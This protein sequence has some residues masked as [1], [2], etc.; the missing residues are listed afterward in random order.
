[1]K[2]T[3]LSGK[4]IAILTIGTVVGG[5]AVYSHTLITQ[6]LSSAYSKISY[7]VHK[8]RID[9][10]ESSIK[11]PQ[12]QSQESSDQPESEIELKLLR[13]TI[14]DSSVFNT[15]MQTIF[16]E[17]DAF[18][19]FLHK[20]ANTLLLT[21]VIR[22]YPETKHQLA[23]LKKLN[24][25]LQDQISF[26][27]KVNKDHTLYSLTEVIGLLAN[28]EYQDTLN[29]KCVKI[30]IETTTAPK[31]AKILSTAVEAKILNNTEEA[32]IFS[33]DSTMYTL[34]ANLLYPTLLMLCIMDIKACQALLA[35]EQSCASFIPSKTKEYKELS[36]ILSDFF[37]T[38]DHLKLE[39]EDFGKVVSTLLPEE[40]KPINKDAFKLF[41]RFMKVNKDAEQKDAKQNLPPICKMLETMDAAT[42]AYCANHISEIYLQNMIKVAEQDVLE[43]RQTS[44]ISGLIASIIKYT[45]NK[46]LNIFT[47][48]AEYNLTLVGKGSKWH[49][50]IST[51]NTTCTPQLMTTMTSGKEFDTDQDQSFLGSKSTAN[52][53]E[54]QEVQVCIGSLLP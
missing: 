17:K 34:L 10:Q 27:K 47:D 28:T 48:D 39:K 16:D 35:L 42:I 33:K 50:I 5:M 43:N 54:A 30:L 4:N 31:V 18:K 21:D 37:E 3:N 15:L 41:S 53:L 23:S 40:N 9:V 6:A 52:S 1:M 8:H 38:V 36:T 22:A 49:Q 32:K 26:V 24:L 14:K 13:I 45:G 46:D 11:V 19:Y 7:K 12:A 25:L 29:A 20:E 2:E 44:L 51:G